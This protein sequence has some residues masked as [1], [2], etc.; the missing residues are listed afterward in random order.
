MLNDTVRSRE[1]I[2]SSARL[3]FLACISEESESV[4]KDPLKVYSCSSASPRIS[5]DISAEMEEMKVCY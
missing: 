4:C 5:D 2:I 3:S 1:A